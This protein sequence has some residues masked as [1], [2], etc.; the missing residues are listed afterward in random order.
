[1]FFS[2]VIAAIKPVWLTYFTDRWVASVAPDIGQNS[3]GHSQRFILIDQGGSTLVAFHLSGPVVSGNKL[4]SHR[5]ENDFGSCKNIR[6]RNTFFFF[7][8]FF[9]PMESYCTTR[10]RLEVMSSHCSLYPIHFV[11]VSI[12][13]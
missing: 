11:R 9:N 13:G 10:R 2:I 6:R 7:G 1:M 3:S 12:K 4:R 5:R 8:V